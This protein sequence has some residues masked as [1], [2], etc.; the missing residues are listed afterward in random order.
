[1][2]SYQDRLSEVELW[3]NFLFIG[4]D[5][6]GS[7]WLYE[8]LRRVEGVF[9]APAKDLYYFDRY[10][11]LGEEW[12]SMQFQGAEGG[13]AIGEI[14]H[15]Y[16]FSLEAARRIHSDIPDVRLIVSLREPISRTFSHYLYLRRSGLTKLAFADALDEWPELIEKSSYGKYLK[17]YFELF[18][19]EQ[20]HVAWFE[21]LVDE[22]VEYL[23][24]IL[25][26]LSVPLVDSDP[27]AGSVR[28]ASTARSVLLA[29]FAK[30]GAQAARDFGMARLVS[31]IK[32]SRLVSSLLY[33]EFKPEERPR[34][35]A[36]ERIKTADLLRDDV[37]LLE[38][39]VGKKLPTW[40]AADS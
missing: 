32:H 22:P 5:K 4:P 30:A 39:V 10:Y 15:D 6:A 8:A 27:V 29:R 38:S 28:P 18:P 9:V 16:L 24:G 12:Y 34:M 11:H 2:E 23:N 33:Q 37:R 35:T 3:P 13:G 20:I 17:I 36:D 1:M 19:R 26:F 7:S 31:S 21:Q 40:P 14:S 25:R